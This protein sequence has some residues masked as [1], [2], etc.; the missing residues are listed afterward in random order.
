MKRSAELPAA[1]KQDMETLEAY[2]MVPC[3]FPSGGMILNAASELAA[4]RF[5]TT[6]DRREERLALL[7]SAIR[8]APG[9]VIATEANKRLESSK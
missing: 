5:L 2:L 4:S 9:T 6:L 3:L 8:R 1:Q 7:N